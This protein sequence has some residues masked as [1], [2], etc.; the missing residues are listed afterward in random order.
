MKTFKF[1]ALSIVVLLF[2][3]CCGTQQKSERSNN[4]LFYKDN[5]VAWCVVPFDSVKRTPE[6]RAKMLQELGFSHFAYDWRE[7]HL[8]TFPDEIKALKNHGINLASVW[9]WIDT[10]SGKI[11]DDNNEQL[12]EIIKQHNIRTDLW[13]GFS[14]KHFDG[15]T[16][17]EKLEKA[18]TSILY[19]Q[20]RAKELGC[21]ISLY[22]HGDW[23]GEPVN[24]V[25]IIEKMGAKD[26]GIVYNFH[27]AH[28]QVKEFPELLPKMLP[29][30]KTVNLNGMK[31]EGPKI[32]T[33]GQGSEEL[34]M[35]KTLKES[36]FNGSIGIL[37]HIE[38]ED[39]KVVLE[40]NLNGLKTLLK[41]MGEEDALAT[42]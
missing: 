29:Y 5:L 12:L 38:T 25:R 2:V 24:Q 16:D 19:I 40:R 35:L 7:E 37:C 30:L 4:K 28:L 11:F 14:N 34:G 18:V 3:F 32:L 8:P 1:L 39:A 6:E 22:N 42:Y 31:V 17:E 15:L 10:D 33:I 20:N 26:V 21:T 41:T 36:G 13:L 27:H 23:F 9:M